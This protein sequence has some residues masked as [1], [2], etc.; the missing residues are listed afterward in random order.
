MV[1]MCIP[2]FLQLQEQDP[3]NLY[4]SNLPRTFEEKVSGVVCG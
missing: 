3:T 1:L 4:M 2:L